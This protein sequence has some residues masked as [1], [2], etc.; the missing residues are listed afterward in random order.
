MS[1]TDH[2][3]L[4]KEYIARGDEFYAKAADEII[5]ARQKDPQLSYR[6]VAERVGKGETWCKDI[7]RWSTSGRRGDESPFGREGRDKGEMS[8]A[9]QVLRDP[10]QR[11]QVISSLPPEQVEAVIAE[12]NDVAIE[13]VRAKQAEHDVAPKSSTA[14][15]LMGDDRYDPSESW[16][17]TFIIR[18]RE[19]AHS[20]S[21][22]VGKWGLVLGSMDDEQAFEYLQEAE[23]NIAEIR[24]ALQE[25]MAD[26][27]RSE[28]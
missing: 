4:A 22:Q 9:R 14:G 23:R 16:A 6:E 13:R 28:V 17:D 2:L 25:R 11:R 1:G 12:A 26:R 8:K 15:D 18:V 24:A 10:D 20:L 21:R 19:K 3:A 5:A 27:S 7:V